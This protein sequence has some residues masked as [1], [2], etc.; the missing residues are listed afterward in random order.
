M[1]GIAAVAAVILTAI[2]IGPLAYG[3]WYLI[4]PTTDF[5]SGEE[6]CLYNV[7]PIASY[8]LFAVQAFI[9][10]FM[11]RKWGGSN[12]S[13]LPE[14]AEIGVEYAMAAKRGVCPLIDF[15]E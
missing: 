8:F 13:L 5:C 10:W 4:E 7:L 15:T 9:Y 12:D 3:I 1:A 11:Y 14:F 2:A 6:V